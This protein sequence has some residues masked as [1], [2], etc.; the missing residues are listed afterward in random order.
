MS[1][2]ELGFS[3]CSF[4][5]N[6]TNEDHPKR[7]DRITIPTRLASAAPLRFE[8]RKG[9]AADSAAH[10]TDAKFWKT[11]KLVMPTPK[12]IVDHAARR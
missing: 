10:A 9:I 4:E 5:Q 1:T 11:A 2:K 3:P 6:E 8:I 7:Y 12:V